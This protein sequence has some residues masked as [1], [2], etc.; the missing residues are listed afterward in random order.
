MWV[1]VWVCF[2]FSCICVSERLLFFIWLSLSVCF[3]SFLMWVVSCLR[4]FWWVCVVLMVVCNCVVVF[5]L[6]CVRVCWVFCIGIVC[7]LSLFVCYSV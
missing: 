1:V 6:V 3:L 4:V 5:C 2:Y 7:L